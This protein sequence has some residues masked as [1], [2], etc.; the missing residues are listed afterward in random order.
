VSRTAE[1]WQ[2]D[3]FEW[4]GKT[5]EQTATV[6]CLP[7]PV[8]RV[9]LSP[10]YLGTRRVPLSTALSKAVMMDPTEDTLR[11]AQEL[12]AKHEALYQ[13]A[14]ALFRT[15]AAL[16]TRAEKVEAPRFPNRL[17][18]FETWWRLEGQY[19]RINAGDHEKTFAYRAW[20]AREAE[21]TALRAQ[22]A[23]LEALISRTPHG[24]G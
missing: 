15:L 24:K 7:N 21:V 19:C 11:L 23:E 10:L 9:N 17:P 18:E 2:D 8:N 20:E 22:I 12:A 3:R 6:S 1:V 4:G 13:Q 16:N 14:T 5:R